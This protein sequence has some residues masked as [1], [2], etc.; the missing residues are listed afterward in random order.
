M[1]SYLKQL[2][3]SSSSPSVH[4][5]DDNVSSRREL[6]SYNHCKTDSTT[7][8]VNQRRTRTSGTTV[9]NCRGRSDAATSSSRRLR[10]ATSAVEHRHQRWESTTSDG[11]SGATRMS[12][13]CSDSAVGKPRRKYSRD[14]GL[15]LV[16][17][18]VETNLEPTVPLSA[19]ALMENQRS[20]E[21]RSKLPD[22]VEEAIPLSLSRSM[23]AIH[24]LPKDFGTVPGLPPLD[25]RSN[26]PDSIFQ[27]ES[28]LGKPYFVALK[29]ASTEQ[30]VRRSFQSL[31]GP[32]E[33]PERR[34]SDDS[35]TLVAALEA[36]VAASPLSSSC[37]SLE[38]ETTYSTTG[39]GGPFREGHNTLIQL[40][41]SS[42]V[43]S[44]HLDFPI[45]MR[46]LPYD[47]ASGVPPR[48][49][50]G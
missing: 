29:T 5:V 12:R 26:R 40:P 3:R 45:T 32:P 13:R 44:S 20:T 33:K 17:K 36:A 41:Q 21:S 19:S 2:L 48:S 1:D 16:E 43:S 46:S 25:V 11:T 4:I 49:L 38:A 31:A 18:N 15:G 9:Q 14:D 50:S 35:M 24:L 6:M 37:A 34:S 8:G 10:T 42:L 39:V 30:L 7:D 28:P 23:D 22:E 27:E 47:Q